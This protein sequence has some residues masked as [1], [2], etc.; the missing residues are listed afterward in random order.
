MSRR[1]NKSLRLKR[2]DNSHIKEISTAEA[3]QNALEL[4]NINKKSDA[5][6]LIASIEKA[7]PD[8]TIALNSYSKMLWE[9]GDFEKA[10]NKI[11]NSFVL[12]PNNNDTLEILKI[13]EKASLQAPQID[14]LYKKTIYELHNSSDIIFHNLAKQLLDQARYHSV[15]DIVESEINKGIKIL[16]DTYIILSNAYKAIGS[17]EKALLCLD[18]AKKLSKRGMNHILFSKAELL[19]KVNGIFNL[20]TLTGYENRITDEQLLYENIDFWKNIKL[21]SSQNILIEGEQGIGDE[22]RFISYLMDL[23]KIHRN[24]TLTCSEKLLPLFRSSFPEIRIESRNSNI[25]YDFRI[26]SGTLRLISYQ[27]NKSLKHPKK[28]LHPPE[29]LISEWRD[30]IQNLCP[31][32]ALKIGICFTSGSTDIIRRHIYPSLTDWLYF[33]TKK[34]SDNIVFF[35][36]TYASI[37]KTFIDA[38]EKSSDIRIIDIPELNQKDDLI[39]TAA[40]LSNMDL[41]ISVGTAVDEMAAGLGIETWKIAVFSA[42]DICKFKKHN[43][44]LENTYRIEKKYDQPWKLVFDVVHQKLTEYSNNCLTKN[45]RDNGK[46]ITAN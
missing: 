19:M 14:T 11:K 22:I 33:F 43:F 24:L 21:G 37:G 42:D 36:A 3:C 7:F 16:D 35:N 12:D 45:E 34:L 29:Q 25:E 13:F 1:K 20:E 38:I 5:L 4:F 44:D 10:L 26:L 2:T 31:N 18:K 9:S 30:K 39:S 17:L 15:I 23:Y 32:G 8:S 28:F 41:V 40:Y 46:K 6:K 27:I